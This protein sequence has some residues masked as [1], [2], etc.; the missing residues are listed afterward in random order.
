MELVGI[1][2]RFLV[3]AVFEVVTGTDYV[4]CEFCV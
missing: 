3:V 2:M 1:V 4:M